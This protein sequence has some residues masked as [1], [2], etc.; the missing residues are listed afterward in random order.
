MP[1]DL[2]AD[3]G[4]LQPT[5]HMILASVVHTKGIKAASACHTE[6]D[7]VT[8]LAVTA[9]VILRVVPPARRGSQLE[10]TPG[11]PWAPLAVAIM[12]RMLRPA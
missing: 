12:T 8:R 2:G 6:P 4:R 5:P 10:Q 1:F 9:R 11:V 7:T 3:S